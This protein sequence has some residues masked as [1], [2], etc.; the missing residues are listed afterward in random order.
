MTGPDGF[1]AEEFHARRDRAQARMREAGI[2]ALLL[3]TEPEM[4][5]FTG[6]LTR[7]WESPTRP[8]FLVLPEFGDPV[9]VIPSIGAHLMG[10]TWLSDI[11]TWR[12]PDYG[13]DGV[14]LLADALAECVPKGGMIGLPSGGETHLRMP[15]TDWARLKS[16]LDDR[17]FTDDCGIMR[18]LRM[19]KSD[20]EIEV[21]RDSCDI[22]GRAFARVPEI[23]R[24][25]VPLSEVFRKFQCLCLEE[26]ADWVPYLAG[27]AAQG[28]YGDVISPA[29]DAPL[30]PGDVL[31]LDTGLVRR[32]YFCDFDRN[33]SV[34]PPGDA[35]RDAHARLIEATRAG[36]DAARPGATAAGLCAVMDHVLTG[37]AGGGDAG[38]L[39]HGLGMQ[40]TEPPSLIPADDTELVPGMVL[41]LEPGLDLGEGRIM[42]HEENIVIR[43]DGAEWLSP[44]ASPGIAVLE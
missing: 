3:T 33:F 27:G 20:R 31:M 40:L 37:G 26:G 8:W 14:T 10:R 41:T 9:A 23:A 16:R 30:S 19:V 36:F 1:P 6:F 5:Y 44:P 34:G 15:L 43:E 28:G 42:V 18:Q 24:A 22:A 35:V 39:G 2:A 17:H 25:G 12:S 11:R 7:F 38:R 21:I 32:G 13:D 29:G 4:R